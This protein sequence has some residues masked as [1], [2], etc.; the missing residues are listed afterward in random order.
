MPKATRGDAAK[1]AIPV[2]SDEDRIASAYAIVKKN[3]YCAGG[4]GIVPVPFVDL[5]GVVTFQVLMIKQ[6]S[7][8][9]EV[10]FQRH[11]ARNLV[12][13][14]VGTLSARAITAGVVGSL[15]KFIPWVGATVGAW[16]AVPAVAGGVTY[17]IGRVFVKHFEEG[18]TLLDRKVLNV[19]S[20]FT[21]QYKVGA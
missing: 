16:I 11:L 3:M 20:F 12:V 1:Q 6:L 10:K 18:G 5:V 13:A 8:L 21:D 17:A 4:S 19:R 9:Y 15:F 2:T 14:L 7:T